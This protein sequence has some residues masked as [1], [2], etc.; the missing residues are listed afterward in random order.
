MKWTMIVL[1]IAVTAAVASAQAPLS[2]AYM[3]TDLGGDVSPGR[4][5]K[6]WPQSF[7]YGQGGNALHIQSWKENTLG[8]E[9]SIRCPHVMTSTVLL[10]STDADGNHVRIARQYYSGGTLTLDRAGP[11]GGGDPS[12]AF[13][14]HSYIE[15]VTL[16]GNDPASLVISYDATASGSLITAEYIAQITLYSLS[17]NE[18]DNTDNEPHHPADFPVILNLFCEP[19]PQLGTWG[20]ATGIHFEISS[21]VLTEPSTWGMVKNLYHATD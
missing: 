14:L 17:R 21:S 3:S 9:W 7:G 19:G 18:V 1:V 8:S 20:N 12:Y 11:W 6:S 5:S 15:I 10:D 4:Y 2:G 16:V 13:E